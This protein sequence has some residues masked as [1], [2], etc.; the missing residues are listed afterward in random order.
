M[1]EAYMPWSKGPRSCPGQYLAT[2][3]MKL[4]I[5][6]LVHGWQIERGEL[7]TADAM[8]MTDHWVL[9]PK[10]GFCDLVFRRII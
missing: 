10:G 8:S 1:R 9:I 3:E 4:A 7:R 5:A 6:A 2:M